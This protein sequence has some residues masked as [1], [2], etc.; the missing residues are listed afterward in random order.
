MVAFGSSASLY[1]VWGQPFWHSPAL[2]P[3]LALAELWLLIKTAATDGPRHF[4]VRTLF[5][6]A[7]SLK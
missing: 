2:E 1:G 3:P 7:G 4:W 5:P 6:T